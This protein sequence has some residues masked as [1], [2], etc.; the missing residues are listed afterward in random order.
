MPIDHD[1]SDLPKAAENGLGPDPNP[2][3]LTEFAA[4]VAP[5]LDTRSGKAPPP[6]AP[7]W[8]SMANSICS[9]QVQYQMMDAPRDPRD[10]PTLWRLWLGTNVHARLEEMIKEA[11]PPTWQPEFRF[12][13]TP[14][15]L[16]GSGRADVA[17]FDEPYDEAA[18][19]VPH[20]I[21]DFKTKGG[22]QYK[23][24][25]LQFSGGPI[26]CGDGPRIQVAVGMVATGAQHGK[27]VQ[28]AM[29]NVGNW[30][31]MRPDDLRKFAAQWTVTRPEAE[32]LVDAERR[33]IIPLINAHRAG[34]IVR[35]E[36]R[37]PGKTN[38]I[39]TD[40]DRSIWATHD[41]NGDTTDTGST[42][43]CDYCDF[44]SFCREQGPGDVAEELF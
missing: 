19:A 43:A 6:D 22:F 34:L 1:N 42:W 37:L 21:V 11:A 32:A 5:Q 40:V 8:A 4:V 33:R 29:E 12:P 36:V 15:G 25:A 38:A 3:F 10:I 35:R 30:K 44:R 31:S 39:I 14:A 28:V 16:P 7:Y 41:S 24:A 23:R 18:P 9:R 20:T 26:G 27:V 17:V 2:D 13:T